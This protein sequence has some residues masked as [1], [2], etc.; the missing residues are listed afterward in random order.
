AWSVALMVAAHANAISLAR[1]VSGADL[2]GAVFSASTWTKAASTP[3]H[4][5]RHYLALVVVAFVG[6]LLFALRRAAAPLA[7]AYCAIFV[8]AVAISAARTPKAAAAWRTRIDLR[9]SM[10]FGPL[11]DERGLLADEVDWAR[12]TGHNARAESTSREIAAID[13]LLAELNR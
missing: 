2:V 12:A 3:L 13:R 4:T 8:I 7:V 6:A 11:V 1:Y 5:D 10:R 9:K